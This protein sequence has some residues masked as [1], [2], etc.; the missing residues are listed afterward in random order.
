MQP[1]PTTS[2]HPRALLVAALALALSACGF[3]LRGHYHVPEALTSV[4]LKLPSGTKPLATELRLALERKR[5][6]ADGGDAVLEVVNEKL[7]RQASSVD[8]RARAAEYILV[9]TVDFRF[10]D[11]ALERTGPL[12]TLILRRA[13]QYS[14]TNVVGKNTEEETL[15]RELRADAAQ[16][17]VRQLAAAESTGGGRAPTPAGDA[18]AAAPAASGAQTGL[19]TEPRQ[20]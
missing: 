8:S 1:H 12:Q 3:Q 6:L 4:T 11:Q 7:T 5:I 13:Y 15:L 9:Y 16:Q 2:P 18:P 10:N 19:P 17:I 20:P 14:D